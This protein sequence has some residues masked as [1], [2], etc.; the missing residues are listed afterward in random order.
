MSDRKKTFD[1]T[2]EL[3]K[4]WRNIQVQI[5]IIYSFRRDNFILFYL[6]ATDQ[7]NSE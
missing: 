2:E 5:Q 7:R 4:E 6:L 3:D 1:L